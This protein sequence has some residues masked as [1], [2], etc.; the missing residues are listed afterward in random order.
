[1]PFVVAS[2]LLLFANCR[3]VGSTF[4]TQYWHLE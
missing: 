4:L 1:L 3:V 2:W